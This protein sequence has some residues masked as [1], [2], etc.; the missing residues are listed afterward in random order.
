MANERW[1][2]NRAGF[3]NF[4]FYTDQSF[5]LSDGRLILRGAN[6]A[7]KSV[8]MQSFLP[9]VLDGDKRPVRL[10][11]FGSKDRKIEYYLLGDTE[12]GISDRTGYVYLEFIQPATDRTVTVG[13][14][15]RARR[16]ANQVAFWGFSLTDGRRIGHDFFLYDVD[17]FEREGEK[18]PLDFAG[19]EAAIGAGGRVV[20][21]QREYQQMVN[22]ILFGFKDE[23]AYK[24][25]LNLL[26]QLRSPKLSKEFRPTTIYS[27]LND[28]LPP[29][30]DEDL[31]PLS[32]VLQDM[33]EIGDRLDEL[34]L[35]Q[36]AAKRLADVYERY[37]QM[38]LYET[39][40]R[41]VDATKAADDAFQAVEEQD[42]LLQAAQAEREETDRALLQAV[43]ERDK[44]E[45]ELELLNRS[46][47][48]EL[49][50]ELDGAQNRVKDTEREQRDTQERIARNQE[51]VREK[52]VRVDAELRK[53]ENETHKQRE[54]LADMA[55]MAN[56]IEFRTH[57]AYA[58][59]AR[60]SLEDLDDATWQRWLADVDR[61]RREMEHALDLCRKE[62]AEA[63]KLKEAER[64]MSAARERRDAAERTV[65]ERERELSAAIAQQEDLAFA[66]FKG[67]T[68]LPLS[69]EAWRSLLYDL[70]RYGEL[71]YDEILMPAKAALD[72]GRNQATAARLKL[73]HE[74][75]L[76]E[77][78]RTE[79]E[80]ELA[81]WRTVKEAEPPRTTARA[82]TRH[83]RLTLA[84]EQGIA[85]A[86]L[87][88]VCEF[89]DQVD[90]PTRAALETALFQ[91]GLLDAWVS[92]EAP[93]VADGDEDGWI[94]PNPAAIGYTLAEYLR[95]TPS[96]ESG[97][98]PQFVD[99]VLRTILVAAP[100]AVE[101][102][103]TAAVTMSGQYVLGPLAGQSVSKP[104]AEWIGFEARK[105]A[106]QA[107]MERLKAD[108]AEL[109]NRIADLDGDIAETERRIASMQAEFA[110]F[111]SEAPLRTC[112]AA[113]DTAKRDF[114]HARD[115]EAQQTDAFKLQQ[116]AWQTAKEALVSCLSQWDTLRVEADFQHALGQLRSYE[117]MCQSCRMSAQL[118]ARMRSELGYLKDEI[119]RLAQQIDDDLATE[120]DLR[121]RLAGLQTTIASLRARLE[122]LGALNVHDEARALKERLEALRGQ[123]ET[124]QDR[125][126]E[127]ATKVTRLEER[128]REKREALDQ[129]E[130]RLE[131]CIERF[132]QE[133]ELGLTVRDTADG[134]D[135]DE[136][137]A[138]GGRQR[139][140]QTARKVFR[141]LRGVCENRNLQSVTDQLREVF[142]VE[143][144][145][146]LDYSLESR[147]DESLERLFVESRRDRNHPWTPARIH[148]E[149]TRMVEEQRILISEKDRELYEQI[150]IHS[151][152]R[153]I[154]DKINRAER[155]VKEMNHFM[156]LRNTSSGMVLS[157]EWK[158]RPARSE[159]EL[160]TERLVY[161]LR[162]SPSTLLDE[163]MEDM[164]EH[165]RS[166]IRMA[167]EESE[168]GETLR[169]LIRE[170]L[171]YRTWFSFT[172]Y[173]RKGG[174]ASRRELT[175]SQFNVLSGGEKAMA[176]YIPL[177][178]ATDSR[179]ND[180]RPD[181]PRLI[182]LDEAFA[183][184][185]E[186]NMRDM[187]ELLTDM[188]FDYM[189]TSQQLWGCYDTVPALSIY[190]IFRPGD[191]DFVTVIPYYWNGH[192]RRMVDGDDWP[193]AQEAAATEEPIHE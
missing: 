162:K 75:S 15:L 87:Y 116:A 32:Q 163:E 168:S 28:S 58:G 147:F 148:Q 21:E 189:M 43:Q 33:D 146:L 5:Q 181:A 8:T 26:I 1:Q 88:K 109:T 99:E 100:D 132:R 72:T 9:L 80:R 57:E 110:A 193:S 19:L 31:L 126:L 167:K 113:L 185:D 133:W 119:D 92:P 188:K 105:R 183:G 94:R 118:S 44:T 130:R 141:A 24:D 108:I 165:F 154:R 106:R 79:L 4:W 177:F 120:A 171:D 85:G 23:Q 86:P 175:D 114:A 139:V 42:A 51:A 73:E 111:P 153:A 17:V 45:T 56:E 68:E 22:H 34:T 101:D 166:R 10:D 97:L 155:W 127:R 59:G 128:L 96:A 70:R 164:I 82:E 90:E 13:I 39:A 103:S 174:M 27:I 180:S 3:L 170:F 71:S 54:W 144:N 78:Q 149:L 61:Y 35:H 30:G 190:E 40:K 67:L 69:D 102:A 169:S 143:K 46:E 156:S 150:L 173:Y 37:N 36:N 12:S 161:L 98:T 41:T 179:F 178:A 158:P 138:L 89:R 135:G 125:K 76:L 48:M 145:T 191:V 95:P 115:V 151:V 129:C 64:Q 65:Q 117:Q 142:A 7:G 159:R 2:M 47:G 74:K 123:I 16:G 84:A 66:W 192:T 11:P 25:L 53:L 20:K 91:S 124:L 134:D 112:L 18:I 184:V 63:D 38:W 136:A 121:R 131:A 93:L 62:R 14:G 137:A 182:S 52:Q 140:I 6:G 186:E 152:G 83:R 50:I 49:R 104:S 55:E 107:A 77:E 160:D 172:L 157:L 81:A 187:F 176:M 122:A 60:T 29:L